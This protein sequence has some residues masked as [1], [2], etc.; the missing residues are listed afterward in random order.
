[1]RFR[2]LHPSDD[3]IS[4]KVDL[5]SSLYQ[6]DEMCNNPIFARIILINYCVCLYMLVCDYLSLCVFYLGLVDFDLR[7]VF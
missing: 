4:D 2:V 3:K 1:M 7:R 5:P 6:E